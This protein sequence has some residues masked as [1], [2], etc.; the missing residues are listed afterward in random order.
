VRIDLKMDA[1]GVQA[2]LARIQ[3]ALAELRVAQYGEPTLWYPDDSGEW[4]E[5]ACRD[6]P[7]P[8]STVVEI[9]TEGE[10]AKR[11]YVRGSA[12]AASLSW[13]II[14]AYKVVKP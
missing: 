6:M 14:V 12:S 10:R 7:V 5:C 13:E 11:R 4:V 1:S 8:P 2:E 3:G 9:L